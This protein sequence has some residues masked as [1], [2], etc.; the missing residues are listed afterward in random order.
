MFGIVE[1]TKYNN[2]AVC[3]LCVAKLLDK[4]KHDIKQ[5]FWTESLEVM[6]MLWTTVHSYSHIKIFCN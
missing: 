6:F 5:I 1:N 4:Y 2:I 3:R